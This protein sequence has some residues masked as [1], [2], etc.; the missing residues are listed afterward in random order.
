MVWSRRGAWGRVAQRRGVWLW[1]AIVTHEVLL[2]FE[3]IGFGTIRFGT[4]RFG[5]IRFGTNEK[6]PD[7]VS[8]GAICFE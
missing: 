2:G 1:G 6:N 7:G 4:I 8:A 5:T 3:M